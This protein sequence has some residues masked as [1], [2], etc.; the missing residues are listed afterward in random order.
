MRVT[1]FLLNHG[2]SVHARDMFNRTALDDAIKF[3]RKNII[4]RL[5]QAGAI[6]NKKSPEIASEICSLSAKNRVD[7]LYLWSLAGADFNAG[8]YDGRTP[9]HIVSQ[10]LMM[11]LSDY[12]VFVA[13]GSIIIINLSPK[14]LPTEG[15]LKAGGYGCRYLHTIFIPIPFLSFFFSAFHNF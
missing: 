3:R 2:A 4:M 9:L 1:E 6:L 7:D 5:I 8:D 11:S 10:S 12:Y 13:N 15:R 14:W